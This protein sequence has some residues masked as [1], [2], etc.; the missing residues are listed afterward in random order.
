MTRRHGWSAVLQ[1]SPS[2]PKA[3]GRRGETRVLRGAWL[4]LAFLFALTL[5][6]SAHI[7]SKDVFEQVV[8]GPYKFFVTVRPPTVIPGVATVEVRVSGPAIDTLTITPVPLVGEASRHPPA[9]D[10]MRRSPDDASFFTGSLWLMGS[11]SWQVKLQ[12]TGA[13]GPATASVPVPAM[14][15][16]VMR[17]QRPL[18]LLLAFLGLTLV[19]GMA[20][21]I[22]G[23][24]RE[25]RLA[26]GREPTL[27]RQYRA[28]LAG[29]AAL[30]LLLLGVWGGDKWWNVEAASY[31]ADIFHP[32]TLHPT[33]IGNRLD[34]R[35]DPGIPDEEG[36]RRHN[37]D[38][39]PDHGHLMHLYAIRWPEMDAVYHL[40]P[41]A[42]A[43]GELRMTLPSMP[44]G[45]YHLFA[46]IVHRSGFP[47]TLT[48]VLDVPPDASHYFLDTED[49]AAYP[50]PLSRGDLGSVYTLPD[51]YTM[52]WDRPATLTANT[53]ELFRFRLLDPSGKPATD[54]RP[55][56]GMAGH[57]AF[58]KVD[59]SV[60]AHT[61]PDGSAAMPA[62][63]L[64]NA[65]S[66][67]NMNTAA[68]MSD[69]ALHNTAAADANAPANTGM[70]GVDANNPA[71]APQPLAPL[72]EFPYGFPSAGRYRIFIQMKHGDTV[73]TGVFDAEVM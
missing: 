31:S 47:E 66:S 5:P 26:P 48:A 68:G 8:A 71:S 37:D 4:L 59:G 50:A 32:L 65:G 29:I 45:T 11:G 61:H 10:P 52:V 14:A 3:A 54:M 40:H 53:A 24:V 64:A 7:G 22:Y 6:A 72:V 1:T 2:R 62:M 36:F 42:A 25:A 18:G 58:V 60:F 44:P 43:P 16:T 34:L 35:I 55:Y 17:M 28:R 63:M 27:A 33:L 21:I 49:A 19:V 70:G 13:G 15:L 57:A 38:L 9:A 20:G 12:A 56:L 67:E 73:E 51:R 39:L 41:K 46:D 69:M 30:V 23:A